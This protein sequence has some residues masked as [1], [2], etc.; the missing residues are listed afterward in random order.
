MNEAR[1]P[2]RTTMHFFSHLFSSVAGL[3]FSFN[4]A[5]DLG[6]YSIIL[7]EIRERGSG[8]VIPLYR[9][10]VLRRVVLVLKEE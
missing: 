4:K 2:E 8:L 9:V 1:D 10:V 6:L 5:V 3:I 7:V